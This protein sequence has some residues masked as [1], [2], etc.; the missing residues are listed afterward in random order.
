MIRRFN[1]T[2]RRDLPHKK[3]SISLFEKPTRKFDVTWDFSEENLPGNAAVYVEAYSSGSSGTMRF[4]FGTLGN[5]IPPFD[6]ELREI[7]G[8]NVCFDFK[9]V[10]ETDRVGRLLG[11]ASQVRAGNELVG[12]NPLL[13]V[14]PCDLGNQIWR[15]NLRHGQG[16]GRPWLDVNNRIDQI[17]QRA[18][19]DPVFFSLVYPELI[20]QILNEIV[21]AQ[22]LSDED[23]SSNKWQA[24]WIKWAID[25]HPTKEKPPGEEQALEEK[26]LWIDEVIGAFCDRH[27]IR[28]LFESGGRSAQ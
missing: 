8:D 25:R 14:N 12:T 6:T 23:D 20:R 17:M 9:V 2:G 18:K 10:D 27:E 24:Q 15:V 3:I 19:D 4:G 21:V 5:R 11:L 1:Y 16:D 26:N 7:V 13:P 22:E 28:S